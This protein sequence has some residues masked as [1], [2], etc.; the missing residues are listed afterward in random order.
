MV[1]CHYREAMGGPFGFK[2]AFF[3]FLA[4]GICVFVLNVINLTI[5]SASF[6]SQYI[7]I[8]MLSSGSVHFFDISTELKINQ[9]KLLNIK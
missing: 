8:F 5:Y 6:F 2:M 1:M 4:A 7:H 9:I 3:E